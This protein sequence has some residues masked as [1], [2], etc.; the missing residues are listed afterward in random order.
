MPEGLRRAWRMSCPAPRSGRDCSR[1]CGGKMWVWKSMITLSW[2]VSQSFSQSGCGSTGSPRTEK[3]GLTWM[4]RIDRMGLLDAAEVW[5]CEG[6]RRQCHQSRFYWVAMIAAAAPMTAAER[7]T[8]AAYY[9]RTSAC[10]CVRQLYQHAHCTL[11]TRPL[12][13]S[14]SASAQRVHLCCVI[15]ACVDIVESQFDV[16]SARAL[17]RSSSCGSLAVAKFISYCVS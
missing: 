12:T 3:R 13:L 14:M 1:I 5:V 9:G 16:I 15:E 4:H 6:R 7:T 2:S 8:A 17:V 10:R 11:S